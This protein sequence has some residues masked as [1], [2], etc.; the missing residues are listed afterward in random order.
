MIEGKKQTGNV[1]FN[2]A[3]LPIELTLP[4]RNLLPTL[5]SRVGLEPTTRRLRVAEDDSD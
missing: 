2:V 4:V 5:M 3:L 1:A